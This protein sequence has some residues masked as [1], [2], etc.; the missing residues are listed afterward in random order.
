MHS[1]FVLGT[2][3]AS[4]ATRNKATTTTNAPKD[5][6]KCREKLTAQILSELC[7]AVCPG[8]ADL[9]AI[10]VQWTKSMRTTSG[11]TRIFKHEGVRKAEIQLSTHVVD[12]EGR[13]R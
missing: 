2:P 9:E 13:L 6:K 11:I 1:P 5:F 4:H 10:P 8:R 7:A 12:E 3:A